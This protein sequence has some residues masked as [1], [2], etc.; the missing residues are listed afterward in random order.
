MDLFKKKIK[1]YSLDKIKEK[2][3]TY[4]FIFG[5]RS[6][7]KTYAVLKEGLLN[8]CKDKKQFALVRRWKEDFTG[9]RGQAMFSALI[10]NDE[11]R[12]ATKN[13]WDTVVY[14]ASKWFLGKTQEDGSVIKDDDPFC[15]GFALSDFEH[16]K[17]TTYP[18]ITLICF[19]E[20]ISRMGYLKDEFVIFINVVSTIIRSRTDCVIYL[21]GNTVNKYCPYFAEMGLKHIPKMQPGDIDV[22]TYGDSAL[23]VAVEYAEPLKKGTKNNNDYF[24]A[25]D[26][27]KLKMITTGAWEI[28]IYPHLPIKYRPK[29]VLFNF[30]LMF[31]GTLLHCEIIY[32]EGTVF[33]YVH[34]KTTPIKDE[35][36]DIIFTTEA[37]A[38]FNYRRNILKPVDN[39]D[40][41]ILKFFR[42]YK[43]FYQNNEVGEVVRNYLMWC[44]QKG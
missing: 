14:Y 44:G 41:K 15:F 17:S 29:D 1:Y 5:L 25:F 2:K 34:E 18:R 10:E 6:N 21:L 13:E 27:P 22:Y 3:A 7:G 19:D 24:F 33:T 20:A 36:R 37:K 35:E 38:G 40:K 39:L 42:D 4:N 23:R 26:N 43:V 12:K 32:A 11:I 16:D 8:Y 30:F 28:D 9:K 31:N